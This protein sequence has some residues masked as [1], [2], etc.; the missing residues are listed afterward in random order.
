M[1]T[2]VI[3]GILIAIAVPNYTSYVRRSHRVD[4]QTAVLVAAIN[5]EQYY[6]ENN[7]Y[8]GA[9]LAGINSAATV[10]EGTYTITLPAADITAN[11]FRVIATA[12]GAQV[13]DVGCTSFAMNQAGTKSATGNDAA[14]CW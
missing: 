12:I 10:P 7:T 3:L 6:T 11:A 8:V 4:A 5:M 13:A 9:T 2:V 14:N 1:I